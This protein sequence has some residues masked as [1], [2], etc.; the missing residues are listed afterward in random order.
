M[1]L[2]FEH[3]G[4]Q[5]SD[6]D[7]TLGFYVNLVGLKLV[8]RKATDQGELAFLDAGGGMLE[9]SAPA[10]GLA[11]AAD[12]PDGQAGVKHLTFRVDDVD[13]AFARLDAAGVEVVGRPRATVHTEIL[14]RTCF[15]R[16]PDGIVVELVERQAV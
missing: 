13:A 2:G 14:R 8:L 6:L 7:A 9:I 5:V 10:G 4:M 11:R 15:V 3:V 12:V 1:L 16:D